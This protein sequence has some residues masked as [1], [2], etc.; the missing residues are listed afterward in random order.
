MAFHAS[1]FWSCEGFCD[2]FPL[3]RGIKNRL[4]YQ[5]SLH[6]L[7][8]GATEGIFLKKEKKEAYI[9]EHEND[10]PERVS[11]ASIVSLSAD[12]KWIVFLS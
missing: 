10:K 1:K 6:A 4:W 7:Y 12:F 8:H 9:H 2:S 3:E 5:L 11:Y